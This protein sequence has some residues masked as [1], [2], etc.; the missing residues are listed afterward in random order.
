VRSVTEG[1]SG[2]DWSYGMSAEYPNDKI[3]AQLLWREIQDNFTP[4]IGFVQRRN[5][6]MLRVGAHYQPR[7]KRLWNLQQMQNGV[8]YTRFARLDTGQVE[9]WNMFFTVPVDWHF[10]SGDSVHR[11]LDPDVQYER[12]SASFRIFPGVVLPPGEY[13][14]TRWRFHVAPA[15]KRRLTGSAQWAFGNYWSG[16][17]N[18]LITAVT[19]KVPPR[20]T[21]VFNTNQTFARLPEGNFVARILSGQANYASSPFL[22]FSNLVQYDNVSRNLGWQSRVRWTL[23]PGNDLFLVWNQGWIQERPEDG[24][25]AYRFHQQDRK[26]SSKFQYTFRF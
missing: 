20:L 23:R 14:F 18:E 24:L 4:A 26:M 21:L 25:G 1:K 5:V 19:F 3:V 6:R 12:L 13:R 8:Y 22:S 16:H 10:K 15:T 17:A 11:F 7:P 9:S 2:K